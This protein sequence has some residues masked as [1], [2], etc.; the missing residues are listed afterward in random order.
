[1]AWPHAK[2]A[3]D[4]FLLRA[5]FLLNT[6]FILLRALRAAFFFLNHDFPSV[7]CLAG[8]DSFDKLYLYYV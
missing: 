6:I 8:G 5:T 4:L 2:A 1:M 7:G 3:K